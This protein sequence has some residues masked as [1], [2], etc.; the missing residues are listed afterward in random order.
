[1]MD[2]SVDTMIDLAFLDS[3]RFQWQRLE[4]EAEWAIRMRF[5]GM[6][7][8]PIRA[9]CRLAVACSVETLRNW[10]ENPEQWRAIQSRP[11]SH[12]SAQL[13]PLPLN[14]PVVQQTRGAMK[15]TIQQIQSAFGAWRSIGWQESSARAIAWHMTL[16]D[17]LEALKIWIG[18]HPPR[19]PRGRRKN[20]GAAFRDE[21][22]FFAKT[23]AV[24]HDLEKDDV[25]PTRENLACELMQ[26][27]VFQ[28]RS[29]DTAVTNLKRALR[30]YHLSYSELID[31]ARRS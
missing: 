8:M 12:W 4:T 30:R 5:L 2:T 17:Q 23:F 19:S 3:D 1:M 18:L 11:L 10:L 13:F 24:I 16:E 29:I 28:T 20:A 22:D 15:E 7:W 6:R 21:D 14:D 25:D 31:R 9:S 26:R 27:G